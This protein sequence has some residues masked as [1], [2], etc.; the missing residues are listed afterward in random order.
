MTR[1]CGSRTGRREREA[2]KLASSRR[3]IQPADPLRGK[4]FM[5]GLV[6]FQAA[7]AANGR[8]ALLTEKSVFQLA[9][10]LAAPAFP[11]L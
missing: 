4:R 9:L 1:R 11:F 5:V 3:V 10:A 2:A 7:G 6:L 8:G